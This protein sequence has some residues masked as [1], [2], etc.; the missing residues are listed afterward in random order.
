MLN[1]SD[2][3]VHCEKERAVL[4]STKKGII[5]SWH[6]SFRNMILVLAGLALI[7]LF[8][9]W[10]QN[11]QGDGK[12]TTLRPEMRPQTIQATIPGR[13]ERWYVTEGD[14]VRKGD[15][16]LYI[17]EVKSDYFDPQ[18]V[19]RVGNQVEAKQGSIEAYS[20]KVDAL[21][22]QIGA[23]QREQENKFD[24]LRN[25][26]L[27]GRLKVTSDSVAII[28]AKTAIQIAE[29]QYGGIKNLYE[30]GLKSLTEFEEK[31]DKLFETQTKL[32]DS[33]NKYAISQRELENAHIELMATRNE[34]ANKIAKAQSDRYST[35]SDQF[36]ARATV[37]KLQ[38]ERD[39]YAR[40]AQFYY[41]IAPQD[42]YVV[43]AIKPGIG[44]MVKE[45]DD[46]VS[47]QPAEY[48]L[49]VELY[50][51]PLDLPLI[52]LGDKVRFR[53][54]GWPAFIF[55]G[56]PGV[57]VGTF[58][59]RVVAMDRNISDNGKF[60]VLVRPDASEMAW[61]KELQPGGGAIGIALL[62][63]VTVW[64]EL[65][66]VLNGF[67]ADRYAKDAKGEEK[68]GGLFPKAPIKSAK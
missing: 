20:G 6:L 65:W 51:R 41:I 45:N 23:M 35:M 16:I 55:A 10:T 48:E 40:R 43:K 56:W 7:F 21:G 13:I 2:N 64:Y 57:S 17:S 52:N 34:Y 28:Q 68:K 18:L 19:A 61:P 9:P 12:V 33:Q 8:L 54:D 36:D 63:R 50:V 62:S 32:V 26:I 66:R 1:I 29:R 14:F 67:P 4:R 37:N 15:T 46:V 30:K 59:G 38:I 5:S 47:L 39:N 27:Q 25:K 60:R 49:A 11:I 22:Q 24:Q 44:E 42:G 31:R 53:F 58:A 3:P